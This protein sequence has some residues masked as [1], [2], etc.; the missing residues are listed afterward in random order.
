MNSTNRYALIGYIYGLV[1]AITYG[2]NPLF[3]L[4][5]IHRGMEP[6]VVLFYRYL[7]AVP[8]IG[9]IMLFK[10]VD[11][12]VTVR[13][14]YQLAI[15]GILM[16]ISSLTLF[17]SYEYMN[18]GIAST[19]LFVYPL[20]V[21]LLMVFFFKE[22][23]SWVT[24]GAMI[25]SMAGI[26][27]LYKGEGDVTLSFVGTMLVMASAFT[28]AVYIVGVKHSSVDS[29]PSLTVTFYVLLFGMLVFLFNMTVTGSY[30]APQ[31]WLE[32][33]DAFCLALF[34]AAISFLC[35]TAAI[36]RIGSTPTAILG[37]MEPVTALLISIMVFKEIVVMREVLGII[38]IIT[39]VL[40]VITF[41]R[42]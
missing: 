10:K 28:Y 8:I 11:F 15:L 13:Q 37:A 23:F 40:T 16:G 20:M 22:K 1:A 24:F 41:S 12:K 35:T 18:V 5:L 27:L 33:S 34:P 26:G 42:K 14:F 21:V 3:A 38:S 39:S 7:L 25:F 2:L 6:A 17:K 32:W 4:I 31:G 29:L 36:N 9:G 19:L 30:A